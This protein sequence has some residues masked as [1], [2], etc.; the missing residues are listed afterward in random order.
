[1]TIEEQPAYAVMPESVGGPRPAGRRRRRILAAVAIVTLAVAGIAAVLVATGR[2][3]PPATSL[4][5]IALVNA[6]GS[7]AIVD[8]QGGNRVDHAVANTTFGFPAWSPD[9]TRVAVVATTPDGAAID[10]F[11]SAAAAASTG[12]TVVYQSATDAPFYLYWTPD[13]RSVTFLT[14][15]GPDIALQSVPADATAGAQVLR[16]GQPMYWSWDGP[17][18]MLVHTGSDTS[19]FLGAVGMDGSTVSTVA[20]QPGVFRAPVASADGRYEAYVVAATGGTGAVV[21]ATNDG[22]TS[23]EFPVFGP[24]AMG[25]APSGPQV[26]FIGAGDGDRIAPLPLGPLR[27]VDASTGDVRKLAVDD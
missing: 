1:M 4:P 3:G 17:G 8:G 5:R 6:D 11:S 22:T 9:G 16:R 13:S 26:A 20:G 10:V 25:F 2:L 23:H 15:N 21:V 19:A 18:R 14:A 24:A 12:P 27:I 7:L